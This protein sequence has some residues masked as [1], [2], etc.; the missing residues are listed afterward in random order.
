MKVIKRRRHERSLIGWREWVALPDLGVHAIKAKIDTGAR[1][2]VIHAW[3]IQPYELNGEAWVS[4]ELHPLQRDNKFSLRCSAPVL[5]RRMIRSSSG[6]VQHRYVI[7]TRLK[8]GQRIWPIEISLTSRDE[9]GFRMLL[10][11]AATRRHVIIDPAKSYLVG[12]PKLAGR[13]AS[14][15]GMIG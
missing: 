1:T 4:F 7:A 12:R 15:S 10:G 11:R 8:L 5:D 3:H 14:S 9:M 6:S 13:I 2:S